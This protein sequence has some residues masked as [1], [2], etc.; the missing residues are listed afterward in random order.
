V[1][2][3]HR[4]DV[5]GFARLTADASVRARTWLGTRVGLRAFAGAYLGGSDPLKQRRIM[6]AGADPYETFTN[7]LL[8]STGALFVRPGFYYQAPGDA[9]LRAFRSTLGGRWALALNADLT[10][11]LVHRERGLVRDVALEGFFDVALVDSTATTP[12]SGGKPYSDLHD[13]GIG[14]VTQHQAGDLAWTMRLEFPIE[15]NAWNLAAD[16]RPPGGRVAFR[17]LVSLSPSF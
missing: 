4:Y 10:H 8:R 7:P 9:D 3:T 14:V 12:Q 11:S 5:A 17:W 1:E 15:M 6:L 13:T 16:Y 2:S